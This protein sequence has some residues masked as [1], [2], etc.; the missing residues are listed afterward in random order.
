MHTIFVINPGSTSTKLALYEDEN[1]RW[2]EIYTYSSEQLSQFVNVLAQYEMRLADVQDAMEKHAL[3]PSTLSAVVSR[4]G[5]FKPMESGTYEISQQLV[6]DVKNGNLLAHHASNLG[7]LLAYGLIQGHSIP[8]YFVDPVCVDEFIPEARISGLPELERKSL[9]HA[10]NIKA[11]ARKV[12]SQLQKDLAQLHFVIGHLGGGISICA[13]QKG[14]II[15][16]NNALEGGPF[17]PERAGSLPVSSLV[18]LCYSGKYTYETLSK[19]IVGQGGLVAH[20]GTNDAREVE[21][22]IHQG[23]KKAELIYRAMAYQIA[24]EIGSMA[25][26]L[27]GHIDGII[28]TGELARSQMLLEWI[29]ERVNFLG[30]MFVYPG[31]F[32]ME[33]LALGA[34]RVLR[35]EEE[36][37]HYT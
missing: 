21:K 8:A 16:V 17:S 3:K 6:D 23:D 35:G 18:R 27:A 7:V 11:V 31:N 33:A 34:L 29:K 10:L 13:F 20:L 19:K 24:K 9:L 37:K 26:V 12:A 2:E 32:E 25:A 4:G 5:A 28:F 15:D 14:R 36:V 30:P 22:R 1:K